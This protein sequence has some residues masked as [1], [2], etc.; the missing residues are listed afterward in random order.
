MPADTQCSPAPS[1]IA[2]AQPRV[3]LLILG[4][5]LAILYLPT[6]WRLFNGVW[7]EDGQAHGPMIL[8]IAAWLIY[9]ALPDLVAAGQADIKPA[10]FRQSRAT[11]VAGWVVLLVGLL[12]YI[13]GRS[14]AIDFFEIGSLI[15][16]LAGSVLLLFGAKALRLIWFP[17]FFMLFMIPLP[18]LL[19]A[20]ITMPMK[21]A[22]SVCAEWIL[23]AFG[24]P[25]ARSGVILQVGQYQL[26][27]A[28]ACAGLHTLLTLEALG[29]L[30]LNLFRHESLLRNVSLALLIIPIAFSS[31]VIRV[32][33]LSLITYYF[34][35]AAG[36]GYL[37]MFSGMVLF[38]SALLLVVGVD[39][40][41]RWFVRGR[42]RAASE[43]VA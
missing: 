37:H 4:L 20:A 5:G 10:G 33:V 36:Q 13:V 22:V 12:L 6:L 7:G 28:D 17:L 9:R 34:G 21:I 29:L 27:V 30:Y 40:L 41:I 3:A 18:G 43:A 39:S 1:S 35:D 42:S 31:N 25:V 23:Y 26:L 14:Q 32:M 24:Y 8:A 2:V 19:V 11:L 38:L 16:V 15:W